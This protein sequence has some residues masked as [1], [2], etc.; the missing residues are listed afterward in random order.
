ML[1]ATRVDMQQDNTKMVANYH[2]PL[3]PRTNNKEREL[4]YLIVRHTQII[5]ICRIVNSVE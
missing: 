2:S 1:P 4:V 5:T 3:P